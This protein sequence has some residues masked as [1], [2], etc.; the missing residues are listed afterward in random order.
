MLLDKRSASLLDVGCGQG[1]PAQ[2]IRKRRRL[3]MVGLDGFLPNVK[4]CKQRNIHDDYVLSDARFLP[5]GDHSFDICLSLQ[6]IEHLE[7]SQGSHLINE[8]ERIAKNQIIITTPL[9]FLPHD[10]IYGNPLELHRSGWE[11]REFEEMG[12]TVRKTQSKFL[13]GYGGLVHVKPYSLLSRFV[14]L[15]EP[16]IYLF[17]D[18]FPALGNYWII[19]IK[20][21]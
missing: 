3:F 5:F 2:M 13:Y 9:G 8:V 18:L 11:P 20:Q 16:L 7:K 10:E 4:Q 1:I 14:F 19:C 15:C 17:F 21:K 12:Y 6:V